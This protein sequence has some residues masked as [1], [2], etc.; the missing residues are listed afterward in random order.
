M[1]QQLLQLDREV[2]FFINQELSNSFLDWLMPLLRSKY[3]WSPLYLFII[4]FYIQNYKLRGLWIIVFLL[5][6]FA[7]TDYTSASIFKPLF[8][9]I[10]P[11]NDPDLVLY[12]KNIVGCGSGFSFVSSHAANHFGIAT[13]ISLF[14]W[15]Q[16][17]WVS[18][19]AYIWAASVGI[20]QIYV[21]VHY[22]LD[23][24]CGGILGI[25]MGNVTITLYRYFQPEL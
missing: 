7:L 10:R 2:F 1:L 23:I 20:A 6:T 21:G 9:R 13:F 12:V 14:F 19:V 16:L 25:F 3:I 5:L 17:K 4:T 18:V 8:H 11:C 22:P 15:P 24:I